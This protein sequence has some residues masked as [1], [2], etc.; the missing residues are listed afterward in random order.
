[1]KHIIRRRSGRRC[2]DIQVELP[3][4]PEDF[5]TSESFSI[6]IDRRI[7]PVHVEIPIDEHNN[8]LYVA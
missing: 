3:K 4:P 8:I 1:M 7:I 5:V 2:T 6:E